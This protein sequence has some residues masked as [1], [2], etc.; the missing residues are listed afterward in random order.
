MTM[1]IA[2]AMVKG[3]DVSSFTSVVDWRQLVIDG[4]GG[5]CYARAC[6][7]TYV[8]PLHGK[9]VTNAIINGVPIGSYQ[10]GHPSMDLDVTVKAY[11][12]VIAQAHASGRNRLRH[13]IDMESLVTIANGQKVI[14]A[15][16]GAWTDAWCEIIKRETQTEPIIYASAYYAIEMAKQVPSLL[17]PTGWDYWCADYTGT[18]NQPTHVGGLEIPVYVAQQYCGDVKLSGQVGLWDLDAV[19]NDNPDVLRMAA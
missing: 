1:T 13:V 18:P 11:L 9:H 8:D 16:A 10:Y 7:G 15:N 19:Y 2:A 3:T 17:G 4:Y 6:D 14:P 5:F 12:D